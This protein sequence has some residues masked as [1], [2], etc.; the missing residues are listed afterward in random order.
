MDNRQFDYFV[1][2]VEE[3]S[4]SKAAKLLYISQPSLSQYI[5][6]LETSLGTTLF[7]RSTSPLT[8]T[9]AGEIYLETILKIKALQSEMMNKLEDI[10]DLKTGFLKI[11]LTPSKANYYLP[12]ILPIFKN[13][14]PGI[15]IKISEGTSAELETLLGKGMVDLCLMNMPIEKS[16]YEIEYE[17]FY[18]EEIYLAAPSDFLVPS[19]PSA[20][21]YPEVKMSELNDK[22]FIL[23]KQEQRLRQVST[24]VFT[25]SS[26][27]PKII[28]ETRSIETSLRLC[29]SGLGFCFVPRSAMGYTT[30]NSRPKFFTIGNPPLT[31]KMVIAYKKNSHR[32]K[33]SNAFADIVRDTVLQGY[34]R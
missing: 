33:A 6:R 28:L 20:A 16:P 22:P 11:G 27:K 18:E 1:K 29:A 12:T 2:V 32:S 19:K 10:E 14:Y 25:K 23:L 30:G 24:Y 9:Y 3:K 31:W 13:K 15:E 34:M 21:V 8:L 4:I 5:N 7:D 17:P 26:I